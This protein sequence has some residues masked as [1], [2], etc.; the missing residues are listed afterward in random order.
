MCCDYSFGSERWDVED[1]LP[2]YTPAS[3]GLSDIARI[4]DCTIDGLDAELRKLSL[5]IHSII[6]RPVANSIG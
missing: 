5:D 6:P 1:P 3:A 4:V 2:E